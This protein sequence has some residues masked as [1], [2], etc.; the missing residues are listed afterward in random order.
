VCTVPPWLCNTSSFFTR[1]VQRIFSTLLQHHNSK[2]SRYFW[3][4][5]RSVHVQ[6]HTKLRSKCNIALLFNPNLMMKGVLLNVAFAMAILAR[7]PKNSYDLP[8]KFS[9]VF[10]MELWSTREYSLYSIKW[11]DRDSV[12]GIATRYGLDSPGSNPGGG[13][14]FRTRPDRPWGPPSLLY[15]GY[16]VSFP[17]V[18]LPG[19]GVDHP[20]SSSARVKERVE[21]YLCSPSGPSWPVLGRTLPLRYILQ[22]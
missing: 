1:S 9:Q 21:L 22:H 15:N 16:R 4:I 11:M 14:I 10:C 8:T 3:Y 12:V 19:R 17:G 5:F 20:P 13:E 6:H 2:L 18:K 7:W